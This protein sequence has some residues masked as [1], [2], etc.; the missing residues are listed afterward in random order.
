[1]AN[2]LVVDDEPTILDIIQSILLD[3]GHTPT[4]LTGGNEAIELL[5]NEGSK[6]DL[7]LLDLTMPVVGG[8][9]VL[10]KLHELGIS[11]PKVIIL[12]GMLEIDLYI[13][14]KELGA[15]EYITKPFEFDTF[16]A[17]INSTISA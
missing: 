3:A 10:Q 17:I 7:M 13:K 1:M 15:C 5:E 12:T 9:D 16:L 2:I 6:F 4:L 14:A 8:L 11:I